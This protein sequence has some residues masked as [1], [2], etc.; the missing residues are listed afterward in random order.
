MN[1]VALR[2]RPDR[3]ALPI[4]VPPDLLEHLHS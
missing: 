3:Q 1:T 4:P 2:Q